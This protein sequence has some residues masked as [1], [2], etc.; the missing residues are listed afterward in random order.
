MTT[1]TMRKNGKASVR[2]TRAAGNSVTLTDGDGHSVQIRTGRPGKPH[3]V[4]A[5][6]KKPTKSYTVF[7][8]PA[9][10][11][12]S[13]YLPHELH[14][15]DQVTATLA[16]PTLR[17]VRYNLAAPWT[18]SV[19]LPLAD[20]DLGEGEGEGHEDEFPRAYT[21]TVTGVTPDESATFTIEPATK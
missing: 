21:V 12:G 16:A 11:K 20:F 3:T 15:G 8:L 17:C 14:L 2:V 4:T 10:F 7:E 6:F 5:A 1:P 18:G 13:V 19:Y 9:P